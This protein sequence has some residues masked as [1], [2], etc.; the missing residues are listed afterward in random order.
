M[1][2]L[3][4]S[5]YLDGLVSEG[6]LGNAALLCVRT[7]SE[8]FFHGN[9]LERDSILR[10][11]SMT[12][13]LTAA[14]FM[15]L[16]ERG[17]LCE[18]DPLSAFFPDAPEGVRLSHLLNME[19]GWSYDRIDPLELRSAEELAHDI[20]KTPMD[21]SPG[22]DWQ[23]G[24]AADVLGAVMEKVFD[25]PL[26]ECFRDEL[27]LPLEMESAG[28]WIPSEKQHRLAPAFQE[29]G[30]GV[31]EPLTRSLV[32]LGA[33]RKEKPRFISAGAGLVASLS[34][35]SHFTRM[36]LGWGTY[37]GENGSR[38][39]LRESTVRSFLSER[40]GEPAR[41]AYRRKWTKL[42]GTDYGNLFCYMD[43]PEEAAYPARKGEYSW[44]S[45]LGSRFYNFPDLGLSV[46][47]GTQLS[48]SQNA[49]FHNTLRNKLG[50]IE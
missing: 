24:C 37:R 16:R 49:L 35:Y 4:A 9:G 3:K 31:L 12:K 20:F 32:G 43:R 17:K 15:I 18:A 11:F 22:A 39:L 30:E 29:N 34:D 7:D 23:Y 19:V 42:P 48:G 28:F 26:D 45:A 47:F 8:T 33:D 40:P 5:A 41:S 10:L 6:R 36:L 38:I 50:E 14:L 46:I 27:F 1:D 2:Y 13:P 25:K 44:G 21:F